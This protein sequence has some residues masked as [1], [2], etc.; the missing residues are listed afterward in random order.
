MAG[1]IR[2]QDFRVHW[3]AEHG[4]LIDVRVTGISLTA[5]QID[6]IR[7]WA[8]ARQTDRWRSLPPGDRKDECRRTIDDLEHGRIRQVI[9]NPEGVIFAS[10]ERSTTTRY[11]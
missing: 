9:T 8:H 2:P 5:M 10:T 6:H 3:D 7:Q 1:I 4:W 11:F